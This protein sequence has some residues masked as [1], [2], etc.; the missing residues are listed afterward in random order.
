MEFAKGHGTEN[1]F[2]VLPDPEAA[3]E[4]R[5]QQVAALCDRRAGL[6][7]DGVLRV[8]TA[9]AL[10]AAGVLTALPEGVGAEAMAAMLAGADAEPHATPSEDDVRAAVAAVV[11]A[12]GRTSPGT[13]QA[14]ETSPP[15]VSRSP[16]A[17]PGPGRTAPAPP[18]LPSARPAS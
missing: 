16:Q 8:S 10:A 15:W 17:A 7:A 13:A 18:S 4:L 12:P 5:P 9:C 2:V 6:G 1:D 14:P 11:E 3:L